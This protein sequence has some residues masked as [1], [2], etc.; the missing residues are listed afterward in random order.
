MSG[1]RVLDAMAL[2]QASR[3]I[4][5]KHLNIRLSQVDIYTKTSSIF[6]A[7][8]TRAPPT[9]V[10]AAQS[11]S[12]SAAQPARTQ[13]PNDHIPGEGT[14]EGKISS[15]SREGVEQ[16]HFYKRS[17]DNAVVDPAPQEDLEVEQRQAQR[18]P[19]PDGTLPPEDSPIGAGR[20]DADTV[21]QR[22][23]TEGAQHPTQ[24]GGEH[25]NINSSIQSTIPEPSVQKPLDSE[26]AMQAQR[27][28]ESQIPRKT[29]DPPPPEFSAPAIIADDD[30][31]QEF[32]IEQEQDIFYQPPD[33]TSPILSAL[34]RM[35]VPKIENDVQAGNSHI[36]KGLNS[37]VYYSG[38][39]AAE[40]GSSG[41]ELSEEQLAQIFSNPRVARMLGSTAKG[42]YVPRGIQSRP[43]HT[44]PAHR[45]RSTKEE[46]DDI[47]QLAA[48]MAKDVHDHDVSAQLS[49]FI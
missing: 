31:S 33:T 15:A 9:F 46:K 19:L 41:D 37:D 16:D 34:P 35:R 6:K 40:T 23:V 43:F 21:N 8:R 45:Q 49:P 32:S 4:A 10:A 39:R 2:L 18:Q 44:Y 14:A 26:A 1:K 12:Q 29:A 25:L 27:Q 38:N 48:D 47:K 5:A 11:F 36:P 13:N 20:G 3:S 30:V 28:S 24:D 7:A 42:K 22:P 17:E